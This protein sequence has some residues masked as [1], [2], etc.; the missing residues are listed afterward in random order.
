MN[1]NTTRNLQPNFSAW[2]LGRPWRPSSIANCRRSLL[3]VLALAHQP[4][5]TTEPLSLVTLLTLYSYEESWNFKAVVRKLILRLESGLSLADAIEQTPELLSDEEVLEI[6]LASQSGMLG[7]SLDR[8]HKSY[9]D[10]PVTIEEDNPWPYYLSLG[11]V[12]CLVITFVKALILPTFAEMFEE[13]GLMATFSFRWL[14][15]YWADVIV[16]LLPVLMFSA[17]LCGWLSKK[18]GFARRLRRTIG[19][20]VSSRRHRICQAKTLQLLGTTMQAGR[21][22]AGILGTLA[23]FH[24]DARVRTQLLVAKN[25]IELGSNLAESFQQVGLLSASEAAAM[26]KL[27][28]NA[29]FGWLLNKIALRN[30]AQVCHQR[31]MLASLIHPIVIGL[32]GLV[33]LLVCFA[34]LSMLIKMILS[35]S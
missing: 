3:Q 19:S 20:F 12:F 35:L 8:M 25:E 31:R 5:A 29:D 24:F 15:G 4:K 27:E 26:E 22:A 14:H 2:R 18:I 6:R 7:E 16:V 28:T 33:T 17:I 10:P 30:I 11:L 21:P 1:N 32:F 9:G 13:F 23:R 34:I